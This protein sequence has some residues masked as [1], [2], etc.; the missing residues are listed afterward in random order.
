VDEWG[1]NGS[2]LILGSASRDLLRQSSETLAGRIAYKRLTPFLWSELRGSS[3]IDHYFENGG[4][5][6]SVLAKNPDISFEWR[7]NFISAFLERDLLQWANFTPNAMRRLWQMFAHFNGQTVNYSSFGNALGVS[8]QTVKNYIDL[9]SGTYMVDV[10]PPYISNLGK[11]LIKAPKVYVSDSGIAGALLGI[12]GFPNLMG[13]AA[14]GAMWE[15]IVLSNIK[16]EFPSAE[17]FFYRSSNGAEIDFVVKL[18]GDIFAVECKASFTSNLSN[19]NYSAIEDISPKRTFVVSP[20]EDN[21]S[22]KK[23]IDAVS[24]SGLI[25]YLRML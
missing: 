13:H 5:P 6:R 14:F 23:D 9:L 7:E 24:I 20:A 16:G 18:N 25:N 11:R 8:N 22:I 2:F 19:G 21:W 12:K 17:I 3:T 4:F 15:Q 10:I 1:E